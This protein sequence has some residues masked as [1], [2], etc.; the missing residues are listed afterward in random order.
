MT[1]RDLSTE[2]ADLHADAI[3]WDMTLPIITPGEPQRKAAVFAR[4][5]AAGIDFQSIT[6]AIDGMDFR[7]AAQQIAIHRAFIAQQGLRV[8]GR[9]WRT[10][11]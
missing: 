7:L 1:P 9:V 8:C 3:V 4:S 10:R 5:A 2:A 6:L 11:V